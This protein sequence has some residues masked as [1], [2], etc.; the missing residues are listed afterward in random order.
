MSEPLALLV[1]GGG[2]AGLAAARAYRECEGAGEV[3][4]VADE[5]R[6]PYRRPPLTKELLR[7]EIEEAEL[8]IEPAGWYPEH[9]VRVIGGRAVALDAAERTVTLSGGRELSY[10]HCVLATGAEPVRLPVPGAE[11][12]AVR[13]LRHLDGLRELNTRLRPSASVAVIGS[14]F[15]GCEIA[16]SLRHRSHPVSLISDELAPNVARLGLAAAERIA[17]WLADDGVE[18]HLGQ[19]V[20]A[21]EYAGEDGLRVRTESASISAT[22]VVMATGVAP[23]GELAGAAGLELTDGAVPVDASMRTAVDRLLAAGDVCRAEN[24]TAGRVLRVEHWGEALAH[25]AIAG[26]TAAGRTAVW[27]AV[28]GFWSTIG[29]RTL[30]YAAWGDGFDDCLLKEVGSGFTV[31]Y[32]RD[33]RLVGLLAHQAD[34]AY[35]QAQRDV[36][37]GVAWTP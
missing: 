3:A 7:G 8:P 37:E 10:E 26:R 34:A 16:A 21:I 23:R 17:G 30:K 11:Q 28:P 24:V 18:L 35:E 25:G 14:G 2:P 4:I 36:A 22:V 33:G 31:S 20:E 12:P 27:D 6:L 1:V 15:I 32:G 29:S 13:V 5:D 9:D 19:P